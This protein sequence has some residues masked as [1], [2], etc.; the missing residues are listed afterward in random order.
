[1]TLFEYHIVT[2]FQERQAAQKIRIV[3]CSSWFQVWHPKICESMGTYIQQNN[4]QGPGGNTARKNRTLDCLLLCYLKKWNSGRR[5]R[6]NKERRVTKILDGEKSKKMAVK[7]TNSKIK[8][9]S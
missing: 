3:S 1:M 4:S 6:I 7:V 8:S 9:S 2:G 5:R